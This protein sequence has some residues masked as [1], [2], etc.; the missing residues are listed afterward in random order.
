[1]FKKFIYLSALAFGL[2]SCKTT[3]QPMYVNTTELA[4]LNT[5]MSKTDVKTKL[6]NLS[7]YDILMYEQGGCEVH[8]YKYKTPAKMTLLTR[9]ETKD[10][11]YDGNKKYVDESD[12][13]LVYKNGQ[14]ESV[15]TN[16][17]KAD[18][19]ALL[20][21]INSTKAMCSEVGLKGCTDPNSL[22]YNPNAIIDDGSCKYCDCGYIPNPNYNPSRPDSECN[23]KCIKVPGTETPES[24]CTNCDLID[25]LSKT[26]A[27]V[28]INV[29]LP[30]SGNGTSKEVKATSTEKKS[31]TEVKKPAVNT[32]AA[33]KPGKKLVKMN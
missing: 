26:N 11:L 9:L 1:M 30:N 7:P 8:Q 3:V 19:H 16:A 13:F 23:S 6:G 20:A 28:N 32:P 15:L 24:E 27:N 4:S 14:L 21:D 31:S 10:G 5:G 2:W 22:S 12:A 18:V 33:P 29:S 25:K 17:G